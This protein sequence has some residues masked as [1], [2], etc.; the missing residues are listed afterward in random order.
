MSIKVTNTP[1]NLT[2]PNN[3]VLQ[4]II[5]TIKIILIQKPRKKFFQLHSGLMLI[6]HLKLCLQKILCQFL[7]KKL[8]R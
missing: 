1:I 6:L 7:L 2:T 5:T 4:E 8:F 3:G